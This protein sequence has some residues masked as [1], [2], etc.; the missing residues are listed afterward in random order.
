MLHALATVAR[1]AFLSKALLQREAMICSAQTEHMPVLPGAQVS[2]RLLNTLV[3]SY[4][5]VH[6]L[7]LL[8]SDIVHMNTASTQM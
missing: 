6:T 2:N 1:I 5:V 7:L 4:P 8:P 3:G